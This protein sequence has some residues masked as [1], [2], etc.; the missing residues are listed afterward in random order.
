MDENEGTP[1]VPEQP[2]P[3]QLPDEQVPSPESTQRMRLRDRAYRLRSVVAVGVAGC[4]IGAGTATAL[5]LVVQDHDSGNHHRF[6]P[7]PGQ[8]G[9][10]HQRGGVQNQPGQPPA[11]GIPPGTENNGAGT[12]SRSSNSSS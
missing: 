8:S 7:P 2:V 5:T 12:D 3:Q 1:P 9:W 11:N 6:G 10:E 4:L